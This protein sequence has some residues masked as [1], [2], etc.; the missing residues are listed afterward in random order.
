MRDRTIKIKLKRKQLVTISLFAAII[1]LFGGGPDI[2]FTLLSGG[3]QDVVILN[4]AKMT[5]LSPASMFCYILGFTGLMM[6][7]WGGKDFHKS[8]DLAKKRLLA[9][10][11]L[12]GACVVGL[13]LLLRFGYGAL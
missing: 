13:E 5:G 12:I 11:T 8:E 6:L 2:V 4:H 3:T 9:A 10:V 1:F 7:Y